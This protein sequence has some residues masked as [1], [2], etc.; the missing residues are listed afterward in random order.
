MAPSGNTV[1][2]QWRGAS[3]GGR[4]V[5]E[6][7]P[8]GNTVDL[9]WPGASRGGGR[10]TVGIGD[11]RP[12][13]AARTGVERLVDKQ[14]TLRTVELKQIYKLSPSSKL[15]RYL[16]VPVPERFIRVFVPDGRMDSGR[17]SCQLLP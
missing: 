3:G 8:L 1:D 12:G 7:R 9:Q 13:G 17:P 16:P 6:R 15:S 11:G 5:L 2:W 14:V 10:A 4:T